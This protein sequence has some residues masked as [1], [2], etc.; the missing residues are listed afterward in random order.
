M[1][2]K[3]NIAYCSDIHIS[4]YLKDPLRGYELK[5]QIMN[6]L[7]AD[8]DRLNAD[9]FVFAGDI[10]ENTE[11]LANFIIDFASAIKLT[12]K[13]HIVVVPGNHDFWALDK[14]QNIDIKINDIKKRF[15]KF[16]NIHFLNKSSVIINNFKIS[17]LF[18]WYHLPKNHDIDDYNKFIWT[19]DA[20]YMWYQ[21]PTNKE[22][23]SLEEL[24]NQ[25]L[26]FVK[27]NL[28]SDAFI[29]HIPFDNDIENKDYLYKFII[30]D[31]IA[32]KNFINISGHTHVNGFKEVGNIK[33]YSNS[34]MS[35]NYI[36]SGRWHTVTIKKE[37]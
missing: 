30:D 1:K 6:M 22:L 27:N 36:P 35:T 13:Q 15:A 10:S 17:G 32:S 7:I 12:K 31:T 2:K 9:V 33:Q 24:Y 34:I 37:D 16:K 21:F 23:N 4:L 18:G 5:K 26:E 25:D 11:D 14:S 20:K 19:N 3:L 28:D 29:S 8:V